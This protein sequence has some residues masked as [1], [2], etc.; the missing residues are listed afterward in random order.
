[1]KDQREFWAMILCGCAIIS[2]LIWF[3]VELVKD[4]S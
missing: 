3:L 2:F 1:V 4:I